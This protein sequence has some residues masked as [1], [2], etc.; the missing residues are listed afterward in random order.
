[1]SEEWDALG[2]EALCVLHLS[3]AEVAAAV[4]QD[5]STSA[6]WLLHALGRSMDERA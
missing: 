6:A 4:D 1:M 5:L 2:A 3:P